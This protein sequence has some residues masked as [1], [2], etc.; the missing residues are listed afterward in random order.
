MFKATKNV[1]AVFDMSF[2][3]SK[4]KSVKEIPVKDVSYE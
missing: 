2:I 4:S 3:G 1:V